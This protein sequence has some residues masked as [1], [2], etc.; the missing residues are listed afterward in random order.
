MALLQKLKSILGL[1]GSDRDPNQRRDVGV[2]V[3]REAGE[4]DRA[5]ESAGAGAEAGTE[6]DAGAEA[7]ETTPPTGTDRQAS[8]TETATGAGSAATEGSVEE[9]AASEPTGDAASETAASEAGESTDETTA[10]ETADDTD[11]AEPADD[12]DLEA[13]TGVGP[14]YAQRLRDAGVGSV[15]D[16]AAADP[17]ELAEATDLSANRIGNWIDQADDR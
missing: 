1:G 3:E 15:A 4:P 9:A 10:S 13:I 7:E 16:L 17:E 11:E 14:A 12:D 2:T 6:H 5:D 8:E